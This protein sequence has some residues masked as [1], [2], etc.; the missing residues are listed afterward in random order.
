MSRTGLGSKIAPQQAFVNA[1]FLAVI[2]FLA[3]NLAETKNIL[4]IEQAQLSQNLDYYKFIHT[5][6]DKFNFKIE[7]GDEVHGEP[8]IAI[9][10]MVLLYKDGCSHCENAKEKLI[11]TVNEYETAVYLLLKNYTSF[12]RQALEEMKVDK[13]P[14]LFIN[15]QMAIGW[16][17]P[18]F[19]D[20]YT[21]DCG[22]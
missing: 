11:K 13:A 16:E 14:I 5:Q 10:Q 7:D 9:H 18:G 15:G 1:L 8:G 2:V 22:C 3:V 6:A 17:I 12:T 4:K 20:N 19:L 21:E